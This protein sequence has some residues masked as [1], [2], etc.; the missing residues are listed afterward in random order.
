MKRQALTIIH[1][2]NSGISSRSRG[3][4]H[5]A[6]CK[7]DWGLQTNSSNLTYAQ[8][9]NTAFDVALAKSKLNALRILLNTGDFPPTFVSR[10]FDA[11]FAADI[12]P[13][14]SARADTDGVVVM[15]T[16]SKGERI[17]A[18]RGAE[19]RGSGLGFLAQVQSRREHVG[20]QGRST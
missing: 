6:K 12:Y 4:H 17:S 13:R 8:E 19:L 11:R 5:H 2:P 3:L 7:G 16:D 20:W 14:F 10:R 9:G 1:C 15:Q 18:Q